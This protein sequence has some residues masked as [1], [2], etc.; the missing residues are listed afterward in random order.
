MVVILSKLKVEK[1]TAAGLYCVALEPEQVPDAPLVVWLHGLGES[2]DKYIGLGA[3]LSEG[4]YRVVMPTAPL[5]VS[6]MV[7]SWFTI[8]PTF[9]YFAGYVAEAR[10][11]FNRL[12]NALLERYKIS[13]GRV[14][15]GG[16]SI[17]GMMALDG[18]LNFRNSHDEP[19]G[20]LFGFST[21]LPDDASGSKIQLVRALSE[22][23]RNRLPVLV[24]HGSN[25]P[26]IP[27]RLARNT[28]K[29]LEEAGIPVEYFSFPGFHEIKPEVIEAART[30][31]ARAL[32]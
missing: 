23:A 17:G 6:G 13:A 26:M 1:F 2:G 9:T 25:D 14:A 18:G 15:V 10:P 19:L 20:A 21:M 3:S 16:F 7:N 8:D 27:P 22:A 28:H 31:L 29:A 12:M 30:F 4:K 24:A 11:R 32:N 5:T